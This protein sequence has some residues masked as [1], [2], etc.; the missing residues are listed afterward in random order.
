MSPTWAP[1]CETCP[2]R[3]LV[4]N[5]STSPVVR[6]RP[7]TLT[8]RD[9]RCVQHYAVPDY[10]SRRIMHRLTNTGTKPTGVEELTA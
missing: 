1:I 4:S 6:V 7:G 9:N 8:M 5:W 2:P 10:T 3:W